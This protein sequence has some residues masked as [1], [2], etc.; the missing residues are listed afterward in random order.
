MTSARDKRMIG[1]TGVV[2]CSEVHGP[3]GDMNPCDE[4]VCFLLFTMAPH[5]VWFH[6]YYT[7][8]LINLF[9]VLSGNS[10]IKQ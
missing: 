6:M 4:C 2:C 1:A 9:F 8:A 3:C 5:P 10:V 7:S